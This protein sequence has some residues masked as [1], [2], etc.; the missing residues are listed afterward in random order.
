MFDKL[1]DL[2]NLQAQAKEMQGALGNERVTVSEQGV[3]LTMDGNM[4]I[5]DI[6]INEGLLNPEK[7]ERLQTAIKV[8]HREATKKTQKI[9]A[10]KCEQW[11]AFQDL[12]KINTKKSLHLWRDYYLKSFLNL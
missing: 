11:V 6:Q 1:K 9:M 5:T 10:K 4:N 2:K 8:A 3:V 12:D 7:K